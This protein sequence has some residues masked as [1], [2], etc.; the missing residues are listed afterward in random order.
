MKVTV[1]GNQVEVAEGTTYETLAQDYQDRYDSEIALVLVNGKIKELYHKV[2]DGTSIEFLTLKDSAGHKSYVRTLTMLFIKAARDVVPAE[3]SFQLK[4]EFALG[5][6]YY[7]SVKGALTATKENA[8]KI[9]ARMKELVAAELPFTK[10]SYPM[11]EAISLMKKE[12]MEDKVKLFRFRRD[13]N[14]N[15][16]CLGDFY[17]Y[18]YGYML[19]NTKYA[20]YFQLDQ[21]QEGFLL[22]LPQRQ[23]PDK[24]EPEKHMDKLYKTMHDTDLWARHIG[25]E[26]VGDLNEAICSRGIS[27]IILVQEA[28]QER[29]IGEIARTIAE[30]GTVKFVLVA[31]PSSSGKT[32]F[33]N[34]LCIQLRSVGKNPHLLSMD[35]YFCNREDTPRDENGDYDFECVE[36]LDL[37]LFNDDMNKLLKGEEIKMPTFNFTNGKREYHGETQQLREDD[38]LVME[39]IHGLNPKLTASIPN[40]SK[41]KIY[42]SALTTLNVDAHNRITTTDTRLIR[43]MVR[44][45]RTRGTG[46]Q[47]TIQM[48]PSVRK[49]EE[50][51]IFPYQE[52][53]DVMFNSALIYELAVLKIYAEPLLFGIPDDVPEY[54]EAKRLLKF[55]NY[56][57]PM[58]STALPNNSLC[59]EF[60]GGSCFKV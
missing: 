48:W 47:R 27:D 34:R 16:Y 7:F 53:A 18:Y 50:R 21:Y 13:S 5:A 31:G 30:K 10:K 41:F 11:A 9:S 37:K 22:T 23:T 43:R 1:L 60:V 46:A 8:E 28:E 52:E 6:G 17:D 55:L 38:V 2:K 54:L 29:K 51:N 32:S 35:N 45:A 24:V 15:L 19:P 4:T 59:R 14:V 58:D 44:D 57:L 56:F 42:I 25:I 26:D 20:K 36:A 12:N 49:G 40:E 33:A 3:K 39:G